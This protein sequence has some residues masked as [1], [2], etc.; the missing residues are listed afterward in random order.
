MND[1]QTS[2]V[3]STLS[4]EAQA[5]LGAL[6]QLRRDVVS[7]TLTFERRKRLLADML[8]DCAEIKSVLAEPVGEERPA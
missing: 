5:A 6:A 7:D 1:N 8:A 2:G 4:G 3:G